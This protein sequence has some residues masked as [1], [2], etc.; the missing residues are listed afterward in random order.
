MMYKKIQGARGSS[1]G[2][3]TNVTDFGDLSV[4]TANAVTFLRQGWEH[5]SQD[6]HESLKSTR[7]F[8]PALGRKK[9]LTF[10]LGPHKL[11]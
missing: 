3:I 7:K 1:F 10:H 5:E 9:D 4:Y 11:L 8:N 2:R 6:G